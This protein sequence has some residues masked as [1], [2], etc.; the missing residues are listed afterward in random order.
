MIENFKIGNIKDCVKML[1]DMWD[2]GKKRCG[3]KDN[4]CAWIYMLEILIYTTKLYVYTEN[5]KLIGFV[6]YYNYKNKRIFRNLIFRIIQKILFNSPKIKYKEKLKQYYDTYNY[7]PKEIS[8][9]FDGE[10]SILLVSNDYR[11]KGIGSILFDFCM[12]SA[13][14]AKIKKIRIDTDESCNYQFYLRKSCRKIFEKEVTTGEKS[15]EKVFVF[16]KDI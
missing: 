12:Q 10:V 15:Y 9:Q 13:K 1:A 5:E 11:G 7:I 4:I 16:E 8:K 3:A 2:L 6:G 14:L